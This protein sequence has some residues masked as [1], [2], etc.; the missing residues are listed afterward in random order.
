MARRT[1]IALTL[2]TSTLLVMGAY[3][4]LIAFP[5][6]LFRH[7]ARVGNIVVYSDQPI[8]PALNEVLDSV[9]QRIRSH[10]EQKRLI[11]PTG[12]EVPGERT[13]AYFMAH[14]ITH[15]LEVRL[16]GRYAYIRLPAW[17]REGHADYVARNSDFIFRERLAAFQNDAWEMDPKRSG[18]AE[19]AIDQKLR[20]LQ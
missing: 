7:Q 10:I 4:A 20:S 8:S 12:T 16:L 6:P 11:S 5:Y 17:K 19:E 3:V 14:E 9:Q 2:L 13:L 15:S 18:L 1:S